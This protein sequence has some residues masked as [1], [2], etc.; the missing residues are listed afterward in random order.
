MQNFC[1]CYL[2]VKIVEED[3]ETEWTTCHGLS[4]DEGVLEGGLSLGLHHSVQRQSCELHKTHIIETPGWKNC[5][6]VNSF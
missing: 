2:G 4:R 6:M 3:N 1:L 5:D